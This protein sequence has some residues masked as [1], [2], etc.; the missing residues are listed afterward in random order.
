[1]REILGVLF[2]ESCCRE[3]EEEEEFGME[4]R[5]SLEY[6]NRVEVREERDSGNC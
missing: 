2:V 4:G 3:E 1:M 5:I 6:R